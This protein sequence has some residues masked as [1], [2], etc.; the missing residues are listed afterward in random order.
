M[1]GLIWL[2][3]SFLNCDGQRTPKSP[4]IG[5]RLPLSTSGRATQRRCNGRWVAL[6]LSFLN[7]RSTKGLNLPRILKMRRS[8]T[9]NASMH[10]MR[11]LMGKR[12]KPSTIW[13]S[14]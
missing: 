3:H 1:S 14:A 13:Q 2:W 10:Y 9:I 12:L 7:S 6:V 5:V 4:G 8:W 11:W